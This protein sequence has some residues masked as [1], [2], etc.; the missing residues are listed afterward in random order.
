M[1]F[2]ATLFFFLDPKYEISYTVMNISLDYGLLKYDI[3]LV[4]EEPGS[5]SENLK[6]N[7]H[8]RLPQLRFRLRRFILQN[9]R[10]NILASNK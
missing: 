6:F 3:V 8:S 9:V 1:L 2:K 4:P 10:A 7:V 5:L